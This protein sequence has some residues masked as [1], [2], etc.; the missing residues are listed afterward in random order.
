MS[1]EARS[2]TRRIERSKQW[3]ERTPHR[4][5]KESRTSPSPL[6]VPRI[7]SWR[8]LTTITVAALLLAL[9]GQGGNPAEWRWWPGSWVVPIFDGLS[10]ALV[11]GLPAWKRLGFLALAIACFVSWRHWRMAK[12][13]YLPGP[14]DVHEFTNA[15][16]DRQA[17][18]DDV[19]SQFCRHLSETQI[20]PPYAGPADPPP[21]S[22]LDVAGEIDPKTSSPIGMI[23]QA[24]PSLWP[25]TGYLVTGALQM[26][27]Q[28]PRYGIS[29]TVTSF[30]G[31]GRSAMTTQWGRSWDDATCKTAYWVLATI[32]PVT[33]LARTAPWRKW[34]GRELPPD[35]F[36]AYNEGKKRQDSRKLDEALWWYGK[37]LRHDPFNAELRLMVA[38]VQ[39]DLGL[40][41]DALDTYQG[42]LALGEQSGWY[43]DHVWTTRWRRVR[44]PVRHLWEPLRYVLRRRESIKLR[45][46]YACTLAYSERTVEQWFVDDAVGERGKVIRQIKESLQ[47]AFVDRY[48]PVVVA[49]AERPDEAT[50][51]QWLRRVLGEHPTATKVVFQLAA[52][53]ELY[54]LR[55]D[56]LLARLVPG[57][58]SVATRPVLRLARDVWAP[59]RLAKALHEW[60]GEGWYPARL[61]SDGV[62]TPPFAR[63]G[64]LRP[65]WRRVPRRRA[66]AVMESW[67]PPVDLLDRAIS[68][69]QR[70]W[71]RWPHLSSYDYYNAACTY[72]FALYGYPRAAGGEAGTRATEQDEQ[73]VK[74]LAYQAVEQLRAS[75]ACTDSGVAAR[76][77]V[78][79]VSSD[80]DLAP[81]RHQ[82]EFRHFERDEYPSLKLFFPRPDKVI[83]VRMSAYA[84]ELLCEGAGLL[85]QT[86]HRRALP[87]PAADLHRLM[88]WLELDARIWEALTRISRD[89]ARYWR[90][91][92]EFIHLVKEAADP[93]LV[94]E[95]SFPPAV[96]GFDDVV[97]AGSEEFDWD[98]LRSPEPVERLAQQRIDLVD[99]KIS[100]LAGTL[101]KRGGDESLLD[102][103]MLVGMDLRGER[104]D[105]EQA[106]EVCRRH[107]AAWQRVAGHMDEAGIAV[108]TTD[109]TPDAGRRP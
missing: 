109:D 62:P 14:V 52:A 86:W 2:T 30:L 22:F 93:V 38:S 32:L 21:E 28:E 104:L 39:E 69:A 88:N 105:R 33:R 99:K 25:K 31:G 96:P 95:A 71:L 72:G 91:R 42:A 87:A 47:A 37:A 76:L 100:A 26:R 11:G 103:A 56:L 102:R 44:H 89:R 36:E 46:Q 15:T 98:D 60:Q 5:R 108:Y 54:R 57:A 84:K 23:I 83:N 10:A 67:P 101:A 70:R 59:L 13:A 29:A 49:F 27:P 51:K 12:L 92:A 41:L 17:P 106:R 40:F 20:Y 82:P 24:L 18:V 6:P 77:R 75:L 85:E 94:A 50:A 1:N 97:M 66:R 64:C 73:Q 3:E 78:W 61:N 4:I 19:K 81:L 65:W 35:L 107:A 79:I 43:A 45:Y 55:E 34:Q 80:P 16:S 53:Q 48:W 74:R 68:R 8:L 9:H 90:D 63:G 58:R 7:R